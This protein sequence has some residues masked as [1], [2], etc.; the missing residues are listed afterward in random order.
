RVI[1]QALA[2]A[3]LTGADVDVVEAHGTGTSLGD[4]IEAQ[5]LLA[6]YGQDREADRP[7]WLGSIK[8]NIGHTQAAAGVAGVIKMVQ[9]MRHGVMPQTLHAGTPSTHVDWTQGAVELLAAERP[10]AAEGDRPMRAGVSAFGV[11]GTNAHVIVEQ[12]PAPSEEDADGEAGTGAGGER[13]ALPVVPW[14]VSGKTEGALTAQSGRIRGAVAGMPS[15]SVGLSLA[16]TRAGLEQRAVILGAGETELTAGLASLAAGEQTPQV[17]RGVVDGGRSAFVFSGQGGQRA[18]MGRE[19]AEV[20]PVFAEAL[21]EV[22]GHFEG[23]RE[24]VFADPEGVLGRTGWAQPA[25][26]A[27]EVALF[28]LVES[29]GVKP[30]Y[31][32]GHSVGELAAAHVAGVLSLADACTLVKARASLMQALPAGGAM[33]A[34]RATPDEVAAHLVEGVSIAAGNAP[35]QVVVSGARERVEQVAAA[36][37]DRQSRWLEV[38]HA[39]HSVL[40]DPMLEDFERVARQVE[41]ARP[42]IPVVSTLTGRLV[43]EFTA[44]YWVDQVRGTVRFADAVTRVQSL[45]VSRFVELGPDATLVAAVEETC[46]DETLTAAVLR[47]EKPEP[48]TAVTALAR[49]WACGGTV[50]WAAFFA[51]TGARTVDLPTYAFQR[52]RY[53]PQRRPAAQTGTAM[54]A[55]LWDAIERGDAQTFATELGL[56]AETPLADALPAL[57]AWRSRR[58]ASAAVD[59]L[60]YE[61]S[62]SPVG[63]A[64]GTVVSGGWLIVEPEGSEEPWAGALAGELA[65]RGAAVSRLAVDSA[66]LERGALAERLREFAGCTRVVS[67]LGQEDSE[68]GALPVGVSATAVLVQALTDADLDGRLWTVTSGAVSAGG[69]DVL[70]R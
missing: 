30:D 42:R 61:V 66:G 50:D 64:A 36:L 33:W 23:L 7:L 40:M 53:W 19:L 52:E 56:G 68:H 38:S 67:F 55:A 17:V 69:G 45:G 43:E 28:R 13:V 48:W 59:G 47:R 57:S 58:E 44:G 32:V 65:S 37:P 21:G 6:T 4:P 8:S 29:W 49:F 34:V 54:D 1:R 26:F 15:T 62:W 10:W 12:A 24:V 60:R 41:Y 22:C 16:T 35:G 20:F 2:S 31:L 3:R 63:V 39:F 11:S 51:P 5:A 27:V 9:A 25:L 18:G 46:D 70:T 14:V